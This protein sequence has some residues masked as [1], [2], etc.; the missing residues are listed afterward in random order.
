MTFLA[1]LGQVVEDA[2]I[3]HYTEG[4]IL[5]WLIDDPQ[6]CLGRRLNSKPQLVDLVKQFNMGLMV[7]AAGIFDCSLFDLVNQGEDAA[8]VI[9]VSLGRRHVGSCDICSIC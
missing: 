7:T 8:A 6:D 9:V 5:R 1:C 3:S 4:C 2:Q